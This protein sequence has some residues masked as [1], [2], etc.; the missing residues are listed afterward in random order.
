MIE[1]YNLFL[2][3]FKALS[4]ETRLAIIQKLT[5]KELCAC[6]LQEALK[7][8]IAQSSLSYHMKILTDTGLITTTREG[9]WIRYSVDSE[10]F[11]QLQLFLGALVLQNNLPES[12]AYTKCS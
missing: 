11:K 5:I 8:D 6:E 2:E 1:N 3:I 12:E 4:D 10:K 9:K 7:L